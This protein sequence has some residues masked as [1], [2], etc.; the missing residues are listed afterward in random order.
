MKSILSF[1]VARTIEFC[2]NGLCVV[3]VYNAY[4]AHKLNIRQVDYLTGMIIYVTVM[5]F[6]INA[7]YTSR[8]E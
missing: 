6:F 3:F 8:R 4:I 2:V 5:V 1:M 7:Q